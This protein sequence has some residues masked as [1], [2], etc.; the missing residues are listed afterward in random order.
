MNPCAKTV[1]VLSNPLHRKK[2]SKALKALCAAQRSAA[3]RS[4]GRS[5]PAPGLSARGKQ[6]APT[7]LQEGEFR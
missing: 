2:T 6:K 7:I 5:V 3:Q 1:K 4:V